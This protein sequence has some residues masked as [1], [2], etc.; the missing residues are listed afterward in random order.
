MARKTKTQCDRIIEYIRDFGS[1]TTWQAFVDLGVTRLASRI[2]DLKEQ[3]YLFKK[4]MLTF[5]NRYGEKVSYYQYSLWEEKD[6]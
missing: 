6:D 5:T 1:I 4:K 3:G 2:H